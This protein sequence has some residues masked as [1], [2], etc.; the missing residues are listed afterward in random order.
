M[1]TIENS[2]NKRLY[3]LIL[4]KIQENKRLTKSE[5]AYQISAVKPYH[6]IAISWDFFTREEI[7]STFNQIFGTEIK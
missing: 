2:N 3:P 4:K 6:S 7:V 5:M 1:N